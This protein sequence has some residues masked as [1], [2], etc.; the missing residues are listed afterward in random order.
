MTRHRIFRVPFPLD[1]IDGSDHIC[2]APGL[3]HLHH[4]STTRDFEATQSPDV[5]H[6][7]PRGEFRQNCRR[8]E[9]RGVC[10]LRCPFILPNQDFRGS[11]WYTPSGRG[12]NDEHKGRNG[13]EGH[14]GRE[15]H[16]GREGH[17]ER[18]GHDGRE[19][20]DGQEKHN[21]HE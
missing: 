4:R 20:H 8:F 6:Q 11:A 15:G 10:C 18:E 1:F 2:T 3:P 14:D 7:T 21:G 9:A 19:R 13:R 17:D 16:N 5:S 12:K